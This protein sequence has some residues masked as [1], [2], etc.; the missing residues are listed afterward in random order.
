MP[1]RNPA[2]EKQ[3]LDFT[4][5]QLGEKGFAAVDHEAKAAEAQC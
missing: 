4:K 3:H 5:Q 1:Y 2:K